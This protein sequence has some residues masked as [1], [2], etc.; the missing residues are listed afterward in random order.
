MQKARKFKEDP[1]YMTDAWANIAS[2]TR[3]K[4]KDQQSIEIDSG[5]FGGQ[6]Q[7]GTATTPDQ[8]SIGGNVLM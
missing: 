7:M 6:N 8:R 5:S 2:Q 4:D 3:V 1:L